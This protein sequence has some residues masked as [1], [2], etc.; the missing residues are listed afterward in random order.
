MDGF[1][2]YHAIDDLDR[3]P[4]TKRYT[5]TKQYLKWLNIWSL[6][7]AL[8]HPKDDLLV[9]GYFFSAYAG[10]ISK[11]A[12]DRPRKYVA[13]IKTTGVVPIM[14]T[15]KKKPRNCPSCKHRWDGH[16]EK[17]SDVNLAVYLVK[18]A[19]EDAFDKAIIYTADTDIAP[20]IRVVRDVFPR[21]E[22]RVAIPEKR[23]KRSGALENAASGRIRV[24]ESHFARNLFPGKIVSVDGTEIVRP[25]KY[26]PPKKARLVETAGQICSVQHID[27]EV[28]GAQLKSH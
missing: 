25:K 18:L 1:N 15:F 4:T 2:L 3:H 11:D 23:L 16:E 7:K 24:T 27:L 9:G 5:N 6:S 21:K 8:A 17:E 26:A 10:W 12:Q 14:G 22:I 13:A 20:A 28:D 19:Y